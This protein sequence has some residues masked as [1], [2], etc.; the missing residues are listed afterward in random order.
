M[1]NVF[2][3]LTLAALLCLCGFAAAIA[4]AED[5]ESGQVDGKVIT[6]QDKFGGQI[7]GYDVDR[8]GSEGMLSEI[9]L[10]QDGNLLNATETFDQKTGKII[11]VVHKKTET[12]DN[13]ITLGVVGSHI[14]LEEVEH[15]K[16]IFVDK[17]TFNTINPLDGN[18]LTA[19]WTPPIDG[20][21]Q[22]LEDV[23]ANQGTPNVAVMAEP[24][25]CCARYVF[26][27]DVGANT[28]GKKIFLSGDIFNQSVPPLLA[29][30]SKTNQAVLAQAQGAP[31]T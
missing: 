8:N 12:Q 15:V 1:K 26:S 27:S 29:F 19:P 24:Y 10:L 3:D 23:E 22:G 13:L 31:F 4:V 21:T 11:K 2:S 16:T 7:F 20:K 6:V 5:T 25:S 18:K 14:G 28:F 17:L 9:L 30:D